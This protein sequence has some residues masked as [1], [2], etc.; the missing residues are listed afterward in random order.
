MMSKL[1]LEVDSDIKKLLY[2]DISEGKLKKIAAGLR[3]KTTLTKPSAKLPLSDYF[4]SMKSIKR[5]KARQAILIQAIIW[6][7]DR[8]FL[9]DNKGIIFYFLDNAEIKPSDRFFS[10]G[11]VEYK[12][13]DFC[14]AEVYFRKLKNFKKELDFHQTGAMS[15]RKKLIY[16]KEKF[17][18]E[19]LLLVREEIKG[20]YDFVFLMSCDFGYFVAYWESLCRALMFFNNSLFHVHVV[21][22]KGVMHSDFLNKLSQFLKNIEIPDN[23]CIT[24]GEEGCEGNLK[25]YSSISRYIILG[26]ILNL[27]KCTVVV[28]DIDIDFQCL[29]FNRLYDF[30]LSDRI[31]LRVRN[32]DFPW[33]KV[34]AGFNVFPCHRESILFSENLRNF[35]LSMFCE[36]YDGW[37]LDQVGLYV[38][39][40]KFCSEG[41]GSFCE[42]TGNPFNI[43]QLSGRDK[44]RALAKGVSS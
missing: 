43:S 44:H 31:Y 22:S 30:S 6:I 1:A 14:S 38:V 42:V 13:G 39:Y 34:L 11:M 24:I 15:Y 12:L 32:A 10:K 37:M 21:H 41:K 26:E 25:T 35:L 5:D 20:S 23:L 19:D 28:A 29:D 18:S 27:Y 8:R 7:S 4:H 16:S 33:H 36:G 2:Q 9:A 40:Q 3:K 17:Q